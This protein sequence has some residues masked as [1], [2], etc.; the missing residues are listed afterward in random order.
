MRCRQ[1]TR[2]ISD[3]HERTLSLQEK[4]GLRL[5][6]MTCPHC[7]NFKR[8][9]NEMSRLMKEFVKGKSKVEK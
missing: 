4:A 2:M 3:S 8:N 6:L 5:H 7:R 9:C 1:A